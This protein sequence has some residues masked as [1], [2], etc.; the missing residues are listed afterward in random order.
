MMPEVEADESFEALLEFVRDSRGFDFTGY[1]RASLVRRHQ[2][3]TARRRP[4]EHLA[5]HPLRRLELVVAR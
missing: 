5:R 4:V 1:K 3:G 2:R